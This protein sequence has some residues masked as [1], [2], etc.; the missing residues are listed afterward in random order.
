[1]AVARGLVNSPELLLADEPSAS[2]DEENEKVLFDLLDGL[3]REQGFAMV[4]V[5]H[6][7]AVLDRADRILRLEEGRLHE[8]G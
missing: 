7:A 5:V 8:T 2:L 3:R 6:S 4:A 1:V